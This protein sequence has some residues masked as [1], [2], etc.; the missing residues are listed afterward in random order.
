M[1]DIVAEEKPTA[2]IETTVISYLTEKS[3]VM[4]WSLP[5]SRSQRSGGTWQG[6]ASGWWRLS[7]S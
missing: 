3:H 2:Y 5:T 6:S 4:S 1:E 7:S